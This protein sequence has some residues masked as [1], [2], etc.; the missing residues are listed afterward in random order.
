MRRKTLALIIVS[1]FLLMALIPGALT[2]ENDK[3]VG[4]GKRTL[5]KPEGT[6]GT[7]AL[8][9]GIL[10]VSIENETGYDGVG[11]YTVATDVN[12]P[13]PNEDVF[14]DG[15]AEDPWSTYTTIHVVSTKRDYITSTDTDIEPSISGYTVVHMDDLGPTIVLQTDRR[16]MIKW[17]TYEGLEVYQ[18]IELLGTTVEDTMV[19]ISVYVKNN[20]A[21]PLVFGIRYEWD[22][23]IDGEDGSWFRPWIDLSTPG[24]W[25]DVETQYDNPQFVFW[26]TT[27]DPASPVLFEYGSV[28]E[29]SAPT[30]S[31]T[32][33]DNITFAAWGSDPSPGLYYYTWNF[34][35]QGRTIAGPGLDSAVAYFWMPKEVASGEWY[36]VT[37]YLFGVSPTP[38]PTPTPTVPSVGGEVEA[39]LPVSGAEALI[40][41]FATLAILA[42]LVA[43]RR[44]S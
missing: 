18:D 32:P 34:T 21:S 12:H 16:V 14:Y 35:V 20:N 37:A 10:K 5:V 27:N 1:V 15:A 7:I 36:N 11:T 4:K 22:I 19:R 25:T 13:T 28:S 41:L 26:E 44:L 23:M 39:Q 43:I 24:T 40:A 6:G 29:P 38:T 9:N 31:P 30:P 42:T 2:Q 8:S 17:T 33:P 3:V